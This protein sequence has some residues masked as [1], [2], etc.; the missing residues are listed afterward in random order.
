MDHGD[1][2][3]F[4]PLRRSDNNAEAAKEDLVD[5]ETS[6]GAGLSS[7]ASTQ[8]PSKEWASFKRSLVQRFPVSKTVSTSSVSISCFLNFF[9]FHILC[10]IQILC[11]VLW[12]DVILSNFQASISGLPL[13]L[14][15]FSILYIS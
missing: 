9:E 3:F 1:T 12:L 4:D 14:T 6:S 15:P 7:E 10:Y 5:I 13:C 11:N 2:E 8:N